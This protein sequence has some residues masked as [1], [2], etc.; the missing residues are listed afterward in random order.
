MNRIHVGD[1]RIGKEEKEV[2]GDIM[3]SSRVSEGKYTRQFEKEWAKF[4]D[5][6]YSVAV[7]SGTSALITG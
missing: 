7:N 3:N 4:L 5:V 6:K 1:L 2:I